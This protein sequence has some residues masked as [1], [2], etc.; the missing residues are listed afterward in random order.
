MPTPEPLA[1]HF[2]TSPVDANHLIAR[3][4]G[5][6]PAI[7]LACSPHL[8]LVDA[9]EWPHT[10]DPSDATCDACIASP[11]WVEATRAIITDLAGTT[12]LYMRPLTG[13][14]RRTGDVIVSA[15][16][17]SQL[18][19]RRVRVLEELACAAWSLACAPPPP[20]PS[21]PATPGG[22]GT[23]DRVLDELRL[24]A[25]V[26]D[27]VAAILR[28]R[29]DLAARYDPGDHVAV[30]PLA[31]LRA[32]DG[33][34]PDHRRAEADRRLRRLYNWPSATDLTPAAAPAYADP[35]GYPSDPALD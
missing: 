8:G 34:V 33:H 3:P 28:R 10:G 2:T 5:V 21:F 15:R 4:G 13:R 23:A 17:R 20:V 1:V 26:S 27:E 14:H 12:D 9:A 11:A 31:D 6:S 24:R 7:M 29:P 25:F 22:D 19:E 16:G 35:Y 30:D 18:E 32:D